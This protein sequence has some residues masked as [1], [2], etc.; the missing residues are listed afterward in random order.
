MDYQTAKD[1]CQKFA[2]DHKVIFNEEGECGFGRECVGFSHGD[3][4][5]DH[6]P[7][8]HGGDYERIEKYACEA[9]EPPDGVNAYHKHDCL[10]VL[11]RGEESVIQLATW[12]KNMQ[13]Q[14]TVE[15]VTYPTGAT[16]IQAMLSG[17][18]GKTVIVR[19]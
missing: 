8:N 19:K 12:V 4:W 16:G 11:G 14:G 2:A 9:C 15:I 5:I 18:F 7:Y 1:I 13:D 6:N 17:A 3:S 10:A